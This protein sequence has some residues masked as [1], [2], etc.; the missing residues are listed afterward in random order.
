MNLSRQFVMSVLA[1]VLLAPCT[2]LG[3]TLSAEEIS[4]IEQTMAGYRQ[5][6]L[7]DDRARVFDTLSDEIVLFQPG[8]STGKI[9]G[10]TDVGEF[11]FP[12]TDERYP[13]RR[14]EISDQEVFGNGD[15][16]I[17]SGR[18]VLTW[19]TVKNGKVVDRATSRSDFITVLRKEGGEWKIYRQMYQ[20]RD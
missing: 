5:A 2:G 12:Q 13:V 15:L 20:I 3:A 6:W 1:L 19:E 18:S 10:K 14:Y 17:L 11:W 8:R 4:D 9:V 7:E 16:A